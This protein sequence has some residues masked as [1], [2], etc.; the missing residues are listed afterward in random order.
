M[1]YFPFS[2]FNHIKKNRKEQEKEWI[3]QGKNKRRI[4]KGR[5]ERKIEDK[6]E[7]EKE[8]KET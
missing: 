7:V 4:K 3:I 2:L 6:N 5:I 8:E 1:I